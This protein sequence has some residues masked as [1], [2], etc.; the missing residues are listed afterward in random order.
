MT[1]NMNIDKKLLIKI[2][3]LFIPVSYASY[4]FHEFGHWIVGEALGNKMAYSLNNVWP[5]SGH[6]IRAGQDVIVLV[7]GPVFTVLLST[8]FLMVIEKY[9]TLY[10]YPVVFFQMFMRFFSLFFGGFGKQDEAKVSALLH[11]GS[12]TVA[13]I[14]LV[15]LFLIVLRAST[16]LRINWKDNSYFLVMSTLGSVLVIATAG[17]LS[18]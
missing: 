18:R 4:L 5:Q 14:V 17:I 2:F 8:L 11:L 12:F 13:A 16:R 6:Y 3:L 10:A 7:G 1:E 9:G 15:V